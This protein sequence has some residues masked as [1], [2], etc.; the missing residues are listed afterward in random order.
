MYVPRSRADSSV[1]LQARKAIFGVT[2]DAEEPIMKAMAEAQSAPPATHPA[3]DAFPFTT[4]SAKESHP[5]N[6]HPPQ[7]APLRAS[8][9]A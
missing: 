7:F 9:I 1:P 3:E 2:P 4:A 5:A 6:P 8:L